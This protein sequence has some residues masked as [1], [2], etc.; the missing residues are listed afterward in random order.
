[1]RGLTTFAAAFAVSGAAFAHDTAVPHAHPHGLEMMLAALALAGVV[2]V[3]LRSGLLN[4]AR[5]AT[6]RHNDKN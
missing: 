4:V 6:I 3:S 5:H 1:M 2:V